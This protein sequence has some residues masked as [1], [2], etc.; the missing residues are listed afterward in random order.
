M[1][2]TVMLGSIRHDEHVSTSNR[3]MFPQNQLLQYYSL[4]KR[5]N[6]PRSVSYHREHKHVI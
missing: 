4:Q 5:R 3:G 6:F 2:E 1:E